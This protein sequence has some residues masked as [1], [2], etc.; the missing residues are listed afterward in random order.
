MSPFLHDAR[1]ALRA[2]WK[3]KATTAL[4][5]TTLGLGLGSNIAMFSLAD[6]LLVRPLDFV[7]A[8]RSLMVEPTRALRAE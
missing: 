8:R 6:V 4:L 1:L 2:M 3:R 5:V 7:P